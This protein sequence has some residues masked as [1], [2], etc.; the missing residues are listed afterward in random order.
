MLKVPLEREAQ[1]L[2]AEEGADVRVL[3]FGESFAARQ[4]IAG[5]ADQETD[6]SSEEASGD[7]H[8]DALFV[9]S[10]GADT[11]NLVRTCA[12]EW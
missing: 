7:G 8:A 5:D 10:R 12:S 6:A 4:P 11:K 9:H 1:G 3:A 2:R